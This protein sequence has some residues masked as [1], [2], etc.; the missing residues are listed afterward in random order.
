MDKLVLV[1]GKK[2]AWIKGLETGGLK[3]TVSWNR[4]VDIIRAS[5]VPDLIKPDEVVERLEIDDCGITIVIGG[6]D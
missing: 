3:F 1:P 2:R 6:K 4:V 5:S